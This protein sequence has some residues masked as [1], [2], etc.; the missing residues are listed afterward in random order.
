MFQ[1]KSKFIKKNISFF[2]LYRLLNK[3][4]RACRH[5]HALLHLVLSAEFFIHYYLGFFFS[6][7][8]FLVLL[9]EEIFIVLCTYIS[10]RIYNLI[11]IRYL[12]PFFA[13]NLDSCLSPSSNS[14][15]LKL[16]KEFNNAFSPFFRTDYISFVDLRF[17]F[18]P[19]RPTTHQAYISF[20]FI[21]CRE[22]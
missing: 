22:R 14:S 8:P 10:S 7:F 6:R 18:F 20:I 13:L 1:E 3:H 15:H 9:S 12:P 16:R 4:Y 11:M 19:T 5:F 17:N 21:H 2:R